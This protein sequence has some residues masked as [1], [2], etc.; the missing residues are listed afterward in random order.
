MRY[1]YLLYSISATSALLRGLG[2][3]RDLL[4]LLLLRPLCSFTGRRTQSQSLSVVGVALTCASSV[5]VWCSR[6]SSVVRQGRKEGGKHHPSMPIAIVVSPWLAIVV[7]ART[8]ACAAL[9][10]SSA[11][12]PLDSTRLC[13]W[14]NYWKRGV[15]RHFFTNIIS[16]IEHHV[17]NC[18]LLIR[19]S[20][21]SWCLFSSSSSSPSNHQSTEITFYLQ[22]GLS[23]RSSS[24]IIR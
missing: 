15:K 21:R 5:S 16:I 22:P 19:C 18:V 17:L 23:V 20:R 3:A 13:S 10:R 2:R 1:F 7:V 24:I 14:Y 6:D 8:L 12:P 11:V 9:P 4:L